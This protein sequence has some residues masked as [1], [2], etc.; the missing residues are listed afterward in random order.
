M[1]QNKI[2][3]K[4]KKNQQG[5][6][7]HNERK[8]NSTFFGPGQGHPTVMLCVITALYNGCKIMPVKSEE[9]GE[10]VNCSVESDSWSPHEL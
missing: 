10:S 2:K 1:L 7:S 8:W 3:I 5:T 9:N 4:K 6:S